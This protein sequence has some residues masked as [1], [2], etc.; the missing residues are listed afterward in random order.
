MQKKQERIFSD[1]A[2]ESEEEH[3]GPDSH[4]WARDRA[5]N[6]PTESSQVMGTKRRYADPSLKEL[7]EEE[8]K[9]LLKNNLPFKS[10]KI[11]IERDMLERLCAPG[12]WVNDGVMNAFA[13]II[14]HRN[15]ERI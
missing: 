9:F 6:S 1:G 11:P 5:R 10:G 13:A 7:T 2:V 4:V 14:N 15:K 12:A 8:S 3:H